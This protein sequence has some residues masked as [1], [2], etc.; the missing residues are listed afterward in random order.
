MDKP[1]P[2]S[3]AQRRLPVQAR[4]ILRDGPAQ[5]TTDGVIPAVVDC[6]KLRG[7]ARDMCYGATYRSW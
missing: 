2:R 7:A 3:P 5:P 1:I 4:P 6:S